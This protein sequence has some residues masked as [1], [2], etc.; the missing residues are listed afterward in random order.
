V[1]KILVLD[2]DPDTLET[3]I[4]LLVGWGHEVTGVS[5]GRD[6]LERHPESFDAILLDLGMPV[7]DGWAFKRHLDALSVN[8]P[9]ILVS[10]EPNLA[11]AAS[12]LG[13]F[14]CIPKPLRP[15][16]IMMLLV[17]A[18]KTA[19]EREQQLETARAPDNDP[20]PQAK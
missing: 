5:N 6:G 1:A 11:G 3:L 20:P 18:L 9:V 17:R 19:E 10:G 8:V 12:E 14:G 15:D 4:S 13:A 7:V 2:D 16:A